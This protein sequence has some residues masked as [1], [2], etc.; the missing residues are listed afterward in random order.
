MKYPAI[1]VCEGK[2]DESFLSS[3]LDAD[4]VITGGSAISEETLRYLEEASKTRD[5]VLLLDPDSPGKKI[6]DTIA[7]R[8]PSVKH[9]FIPKEKAIKHH[10]VGVAESD[11]ETVLESLANL[12]PER[13]ENHMPVISMTD[14]YE[15][16]LAGN[17]E[18]SA[19][20]F[21]IGQKLHIGITNAKTFLKR[22]NAL[23]ISK[24]KLE[25]LING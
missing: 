8:I 4:I 20:R 17:N 25:A 11:K 6:R 19:L 22:I 5:I 10:K 14:L 13:S 1:I 15:L 21:E 2:T 16:G 18:S 7:N 12:V 24:E 23:G 3:F 9:A